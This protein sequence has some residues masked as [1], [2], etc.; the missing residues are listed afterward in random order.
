VDT[1]PGIKSVRDIENERAQG[2][3]HEALK[4]FKSLAEVNRNFGSSVQ[5]ESK[6]TYGATSPKSPSG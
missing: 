5:N 1:N 2:E 3:I 6:N 4:G